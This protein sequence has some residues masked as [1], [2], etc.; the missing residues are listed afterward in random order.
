MY[1]QSTFSGPTVEEAW[2]VVE[3]KAVANRRER[4]Q[5]G[6][7]GVEY[8]LVLEGVHCPAE[9]SQQTH[10]AFVYRVRSGP[11][12]PMPSRAVARINHINILY[13]VTCMT[14]S[15]SIPSYF[16]TNNASVVFVKVLCLWTYL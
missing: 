1:G 5:R 8:S 15:S 13:R 4:L 14:Y 16:D 7:V 3:S 9:L 12:L 10:N 11:I 6:C 2:V